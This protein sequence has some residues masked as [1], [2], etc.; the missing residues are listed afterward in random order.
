MTERTAT[1]V[2]VF[3]IGHGNRS[4]SDFIAQ[5]RAVAIA[6]LVDVRAY[7]SSRRHP[8]FARMALEPAL[9]A[10]RI[11][12]LWEGPALGGMR[13]PRSGSPHTAL[14]DPALRGY[15][16]HMASEEFA[17]AVSRL[18]KLAAKTRVALMCE[19]RD[20]RHCHRAFIADAL[21]LA[22][23]EVLHLVDLND[24]RLHALGEAARVAAGS[25]VYDAGVQLDFALRQRD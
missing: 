16:D 10:A 13:R 1:A 3:T 17:D 7:P 20:H 8:Q 14:T 5:L 9:R 24:V 25:L 22:G 19:E 21:L 4:S 18:L 11:R 2:T 6:C 12:Y 23:T 15:A